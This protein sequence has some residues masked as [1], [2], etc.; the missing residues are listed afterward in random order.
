MQTKLLTRIEAMDY[1]KISKGT[2]GKYV[3][4]G[5]IRPLKAS[6]QNVTNR[7]RYDPSQLDRV[8]I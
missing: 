4:L 3:K 2:F 5:L 1:L 7:K 6:K 8:W